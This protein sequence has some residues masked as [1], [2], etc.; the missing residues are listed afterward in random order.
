[1]RRH[2]IILA[3]NDLGRINLYK[4]VTESHLTYYAG[5]HPRIPKSLVM[6]YRDGLIL[7]SA[8]E[9]GELCVRL[10]ISFSFSIW[11]SFRNIHAVHSA[12]STAR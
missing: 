3:K 1:M 6:K 9:A 4:L 2:A 10:K 11:I 8:C 7:G 5:R 12:S